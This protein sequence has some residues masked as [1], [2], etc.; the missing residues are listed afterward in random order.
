MVNFLLYKCSYGLIAAQYRFSEI[1]LDY[2]GD[3][4]WE[5]DSFMALFRSKSRDAVFR[6]ATRMDGWRKVPAFQNK[7]KNRGKGERE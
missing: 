6:T 4:V 5:K 7:H 3:R 2:F 1:K